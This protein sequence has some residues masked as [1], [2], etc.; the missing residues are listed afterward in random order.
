M[1]ISSHA[2][3]KRD[4]SR[5]RHGALRVLCAEDDPCIAK[6]LKIGLDGV[7]H[8]VECV[9]NGSDAVERIRAKPDFFDLVITDHRMPN[10]TGMTLVQA[11]REMA[12]LRRIFV[13][14]SALGLAD[15]EAYRRLAVDRM[16]EKPSESG[17]LMRAVAEFV[18]AK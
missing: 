14:S 1:T 16:V 9:A 4:V 18:R 8:F 11:L 15:K 5:N 2:L 7:G 6:L 12:F 13:H 17:E 10:G 3:S